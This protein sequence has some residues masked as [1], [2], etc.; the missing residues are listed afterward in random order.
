MEP[1]FAMV[2]SLPLPK[3]LLKLIETGRCPR[4]HEEELHQNIR[5]LVSKER[6]R[7]FAPDQDR[8]CLVRPPFSTVAER[9]AAQEGEFWSRFGAVEQISPD[10]LIF[11]GDFGLGSDSPILLD[12][13]KD[14]LNRAVIR[15]KWNYG[16]GPRNQWLLCSESFDA[17]SDVL[18]LEHGI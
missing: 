4:T 10:S 7:S 9:I 14:R 6:V 13:R 18:G 12:Y 3:G 17:F 15:L 5:P 2:G 11:I 8:I 16:E 1:D